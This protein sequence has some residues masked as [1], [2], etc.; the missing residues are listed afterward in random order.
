MS[1]GERLPWVF[2][3]AVFPVYEVDDLEDGSG[4]LFEFD[5]VERHGDGYSWA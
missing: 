3:E 4:G 2:F 5:P 1:F